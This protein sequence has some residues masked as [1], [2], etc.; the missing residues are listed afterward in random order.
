MDANT[1]PGAPM[2]SRLP[3]GLRLPDEDAGP[4]TPLLTDALAFLEE[5]H[6]AVNRL[7]AVLDETLG[8]G[9]RADAF[10]RVA[11]VLAIH[12]AIEE[13]Y[14]YPAIRTAG[15]EDLLLDSLHEH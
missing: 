3:S 1:K 15:T 13:R 14:F 10:R 2:S 4:S 5:Q 9:E 7:F 11:D 6:L 8:A 12:T